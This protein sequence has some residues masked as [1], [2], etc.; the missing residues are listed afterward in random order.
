MLSGPRILCLAL[1][2]L[3]LA[4]VAW[5]G[6]AGAP[7]TP[8]EKDALFARIERNAAGAREGD[9]HLLERLHTL[10]DSD[11]GK[12]FYMLNLIRF[13]EQALYPPGSPYTGSALD[14]DARYNRA[15]APLLLRHGNVP[16]FIGAPEGRFL[17]QAGDMEW[18]RIAIV[19]YRSRRDLLEMVADLAGKP[20]G[21]HKW[22]SIERTQV[23]PVRAAFSMIF[24]R[25]AA[26]VLLALLG[27]GLH[28]LLRRWL[29]YR[30]TATGAAR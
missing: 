15:I 7:M 3:Y 19:R 18:Q 16:V 9:G 11:D 8:Q 21:V 10:A 4:F 13:R 24:V 29:R 23:F 2:A 22:A 6:G 1:L 14:A 5:Y 25:G 17:D 26:A 12:E 20:V 30:G 27:A 28:L